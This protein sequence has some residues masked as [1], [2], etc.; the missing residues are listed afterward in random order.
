MGLARG[1]VHTSNA[2]FPNGSAHDELQF[3][4]TKPFPCHTETCGFSHTGKANYREAAG[5]SLPYAYCTHPR[6]DLLKTVWYAVRG[7]VLQFA[8]MWIKQISR[9][10]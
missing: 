9:L 10:S 3:E 6:C 2:L 4:G 1:E 8:A 7:P 5:M